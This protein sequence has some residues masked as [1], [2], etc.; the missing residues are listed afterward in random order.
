MASSTDERA[1]S[2]PASAG[3]GAAPVGPYRGRFG[4][5]RPAALAA[6]PLPPARM[7][8]RRGARPLKRWRY[9]G[10]YGPELMLC[11][12]LARVGVAHQAFWAVWER[13]ARRL[14]ERTR[15]SRGGVELSMERPGR[16]R[17]SDR[18]GRLEIEIDLLVEEVDGV[19]TISPH[20]RSLIWTRKQGGVP[21]HGTVRIGDA[22]HALD[23]L[24]VVDDSAGWHARR[25][26]WRWSAGV[27][28][29][30]DGRTAAWNLVDGVHDA[31]AGGS[32][33]TVWLDG[34]PVEAAP[35]V[36]AADL[37]A[38]STPAD[39]GDLRFAT[40]AVRERRENML[41]VRS[42]Y[43]QPFG[44]FGGALPGGIQLAEGFGVMEQHSAV[45]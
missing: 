35:A 19:E 34:A 37:S 36:F 7:P 28:R 44:T 45:W 14:H 9:V 31:A 39:G 3:P 22:V 10:V 25:T 33:R 15:L 12:G 26:D 16:V 23:A 13:E 18:A 17:V 38:V 41:L 30:A 5:A 20:G 4:A 1:A 43:R 40:E 2:A 6:L 24:A 32:E 21:A 11:V 27:G 8:L 42:S 29:T